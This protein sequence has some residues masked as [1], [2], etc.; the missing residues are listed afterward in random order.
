M[1]SCVYKILLLILC[2]IHICEHF[3]AQDWILAINNPTLNLEYAHTYHRTQGVC[4]RHFATSQ[5]TTPA[6][7]RL[8]RGV[9]PTLFLPARDNCENGLSASEIQKAFL[10]SARLVIAY[11]LH[12]TVILCCLLWVLRK[13]IKRIFMLINLKNTSSFFPMCN[14]VVLQVE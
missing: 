10:S 12:H 2:F 1:T 11:F 5:F 4:H 13:K 7:V 3:S 6:R 9:V 8:N 14:R